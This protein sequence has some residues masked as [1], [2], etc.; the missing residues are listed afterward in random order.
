MG[1]PPVRMPGRLTIDKNRISVLNKD[2]EEKYGFFSIFSVR[3][4]RILY[5]EN[6][7]GNQTRRRFNKQ[8]KTLIHKTA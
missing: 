7:T 2:E 4:V 8:E 6:Q 1:R 5:D 3:S